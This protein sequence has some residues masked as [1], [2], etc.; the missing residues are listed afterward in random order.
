MKLLFFRLKSW[1]FEKL[2][3][4]AKA[5]SQPKKPQNFFCEKCCWADVLTPYFKEGGG[6]SLYTFL[7]VTH[8][9]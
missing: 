9:T 5:G 6:L 4:A 7:P 2:T 1:N 8:Y 3:T